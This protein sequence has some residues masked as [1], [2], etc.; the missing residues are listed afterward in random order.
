VPDK[1]PHPA[2]SHKKK[3]PR[4][5]RRSASWLTTPSNGKQ[6][7]Q[8]AASHCRGPELTQHHM[9]LHALPS[10][11]LVC[12]AQL[13]SCTFIP[14]TLSAS[15]PSHPHSTAIHTTSCSLLTLTDLPELPLWLQCSSC[16]HSRN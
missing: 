14:H 13:A 11:L 8:P 12:V 1:P 2:G 4:H 3:K 5:M 7:Q 9:H 6:Q 10:V 15:R 16:G